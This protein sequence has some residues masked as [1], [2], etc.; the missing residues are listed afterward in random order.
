MKMV[1][2]KCKYCGR[3]LGKAYGTVVAELKCPNSDCRATTH[4][5]I[6]HSDTTADITYKFITKEIQPKGEIK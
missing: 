3:H 1:E 4:F 2:L 6:V 5:K